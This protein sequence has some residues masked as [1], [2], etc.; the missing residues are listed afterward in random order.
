MSKVIVEEVATEEIKQAPQLVEEVKLPTQEVVEVEEKPNYMWLIILIALLVGALTGGFITYFSGLSR[1]KETESTPLPVATLIPT[2]EPV[3]SASPSPIKREELKV[4]ILNG[5]GVSG[6]ASKAKALL[7]GLGYTSIDTGNAL[8]SD[9][10]QTEVS[11]KSSAKELFTTVIKD[12][13]KSYNAVESSKPL[14]ETSKYDIVITLG[15][16]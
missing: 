9:L 12:L 16:K 6:A 11:V 13:S 7:T 4:Q 14:I 2:I 10:V 5:S 1:M 15:K 3:P 8:I